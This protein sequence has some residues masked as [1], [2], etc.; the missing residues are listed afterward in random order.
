[1]HPFHPGVENNEFIPAATPVTPEEPA[2]PPV[3][4]ATFFNRMDLNN[5]VSLII[6]TMD[7]SDF[8]VLTAATVD[9][10]YS[11]VQAKTAIALI[12]CA[13]AGDLCSFF[14]AATSTDSKMAER[15]RNSMRD[16]LAG[17]T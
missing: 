15:V 10:P 12:A 9:R 7:A 4:W 8:R 11:V 1:M 14:V 13:P 2:A 5:A 16:Q 3:Y 17:R 6:T